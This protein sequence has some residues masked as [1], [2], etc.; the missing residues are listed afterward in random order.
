MKVILRLNELLEKGGHGDQCM[1]SVSKP[2]KE[3]KKESWV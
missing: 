3:R 1:L 2:R